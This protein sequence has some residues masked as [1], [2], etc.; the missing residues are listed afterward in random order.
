MTL[1]ETLNE[2]LVKLFKDILEIEAKSLI[3]EEFKDITYNDMHIIEAVGVDEPRNM[4]T[5]AKLMSVTTGTLTKAMDALCDKGY[6]VRER[7][8]K[9]KR[10]I[11]L[12][13]TD[14]G[15]SAYYH[16][17]QFHRQMIKNIASEMTEQETE[18]LIYALAKL[19]D[20]FHLNYYDTKEDS[21]YIDWAKIK[22]KEDEE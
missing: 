1:E 8:T 16:H 13:L 4:K 18:I 15:K 11:K 12:R 14:K 7:S 17:E 21:Q 9:D 19:V 2:L 10:V 3:T 5:V 6:V 22:Q 20:Y